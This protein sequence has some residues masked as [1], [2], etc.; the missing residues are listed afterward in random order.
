MPVMT[1]KKT[2][3]T[4]ETKRFESQIHLYELEFC[5]GIIDKEAL[6]KGFDRY[7]EELQKYVVLKDSG[8][9]N[10]NTQKYDTMTISDVAKGLTGPN[11]Y[12]NMTNPDDI[13]KYVVLKDS[14]VTNPPYNASHPKVTTDS[15]SINIL[16]YCSE[17]PVFIKALDKANNPAIEEAI[18]NTITNK[19]NIHFTTNDIN[20]T[21]ILS[22]TKLVT[23]AFK[24]VSRTISR[25]F[26]KS[27]T[28]QTQTSS[29]DSDFM[30]SS[31]YNPQKFYNLITDKDKLPKLMVNKQY[32]FIGTHSKFLIEFLKVVSSDIHAYFD[33]LDICQIDLSE[34][35]K[36]VKVA[37]RHFSND[38]KE[39]E[40]QKNKNSG[41]GASFYKLFMM[42]HCVACHNLLDI[43]HPIA[44]LLDKGTGKMVQH[45]VEFSKS[46]YGYNKYSLCS[47]YNITEL[48][49]KRDV[50][51]DIFKSE[52][53]GI[54]NVI[55]GSSII[56]RAIITTILFIYIMKGEPNY[57]Y[58][59]YGFLDESSDEP[60]DEPLAENITNA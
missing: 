9:T 11:H 50:L 32:I 57:N 12:D 39:E 49:S 7:L 53:G 1:S 14:G 10:P 52:C 45:F 29:L 34:Q 13:Q 16:P 3:N 26:S 24:T 37:V 42:R 60:L 56:L 59:D 40:E 15:I 31:E 46:Q 30:Y 6:Y 43:K 5:D 18:L 23:D 35:C 27:P 51:L 20:K 33:N 44:K 25:K 2:K 47:P 58:T 22:P 8:V 38:Y 48:Y 41:V 19:F 55:F 17:R 36:I 54:D 28:P 4:K 21:K